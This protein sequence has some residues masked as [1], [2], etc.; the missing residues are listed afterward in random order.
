MN[1]GLN[2]RLPEVPSFPHNLDAS[3][4]QPSSHEK[5]NLLLNELGALPDEGSEAEQHGAGDPVVLAAQAHRPCIHYATVVEPKVFYTQPCVDTV[6]ATAGDVGFVT[7]VDPEPMKSAVEDFVTGIGPL[8]FTLAFPAGC[9]IRVVD[10][11]ESRWVHSAGAASILTQ[12]TDFEVL[13]HGF[14]KLQ[15]HL[16][17]RISHGALE[18][19]FIECTALVQRLDT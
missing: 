19:G 9:R 1:I 11:C 12:Q 17:V 16:R 7:L 2:V 15:H 6:V 13:G 18:F 5:V 10:G 3:V 4:F 8:P 14:G